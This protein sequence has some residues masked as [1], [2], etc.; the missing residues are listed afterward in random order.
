V[1]F[2]V[3]IAGIFLPFPFN[4][5]LLDGL[6]DNGIHETRAQ[7]QKINEFLFEVQKIKKVDVFYSWVIE[8]GLGQFDDE[9][10]CLFGLELVFYFCDEEGTKLTC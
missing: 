6:V 9:V 2:N 10:N 3:I 8:T 5:K 1:D 4:V 7:N